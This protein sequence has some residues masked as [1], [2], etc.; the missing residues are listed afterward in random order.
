M[1]IYQEFFPACS[2]CGIKDLIN[3]LYLDCNTYGSVNLHFHMVPKYSRD[4]HSMQERGIPDR[5]REVN[6]DF[7][8]QEHLFLV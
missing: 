4:N 3:L 2:Q 1:Y 6:K 7:F 8:L 5:Q